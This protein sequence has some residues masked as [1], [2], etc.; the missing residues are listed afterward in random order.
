MK[1]PSCTN[2]ITL[3]NIM[4]LEGCVC[5]G[6]GQHLKYNWVYIASGGV[7]ASLMFEGV[8]RIIL[9]ITGSYSYSWF[10][11][12]FLSFSAYAVALNLFLPL[13]KK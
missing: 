8:M 5:G 4:R 11:S 13:E 6:C 9:P 10:I 12:A 2:K 7:F 1:C 3:L